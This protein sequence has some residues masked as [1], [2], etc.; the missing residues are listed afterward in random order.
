MMKV[1]VTDGTSEE[2]VAC[3]KG[4]AHIAMKPVLKPEELLAIIGDYEGLIETGRAHV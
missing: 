4:V 2:G 1:L 3:L